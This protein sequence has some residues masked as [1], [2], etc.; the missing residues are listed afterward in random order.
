MTGRAGGRADGGGRKEGERLPN[1][2]RSEIL[3][4]RGRGREGCRSFPLARAP[5][6]HGREARGGRGRGAT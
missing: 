5:R 3:G 1:A 6:V 2:S 4:R